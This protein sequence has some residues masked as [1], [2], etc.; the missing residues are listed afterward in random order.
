M[1]LDAAGLSAEALRGLIEEFVSRDGT[2]YGNLEKTLDEKVS[3]VMRQLE[4]GEVCL[5]FDRE[6]ERA[7]LVPA[8]DLE[9]SLG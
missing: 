2:D 7:N 9:D 6:E 3:A 5:V 4:D 1:P 8:R